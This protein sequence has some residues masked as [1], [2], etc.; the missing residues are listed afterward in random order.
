MD[1]SDFREEIVN[2]GQLK[3]CKKP[4]NALLCWYKI[5]FTKDYV[6]ETK[7]KNCFMNHMAIVFKSD[8]TDKICNMK[9]VMIKILQMKD[10]VKINLL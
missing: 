7:R 10:T 4:P 5:V 8:L 6:I 1:D 2:F 9:D 3:N